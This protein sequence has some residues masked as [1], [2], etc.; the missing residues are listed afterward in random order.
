[1]DLREKI[2]RSREL[3]TEGQLL[4]WRDIIDKYYSHGY[5]MGVWD[6]KVI[7]GLNA[8]RRERKFNKEEFYK[9]MERLKKEPYIENEYIKSLNKNIPEEVRKIRNIL[10]ITLQDIADMKKGEADAIYEGALGL[11]QLVYKIEQAHKD[12]D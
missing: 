6:T 2:K 4:F 9:E 1:M 5:R 8:K 12:E 10:G 7:S 3:S 11:K